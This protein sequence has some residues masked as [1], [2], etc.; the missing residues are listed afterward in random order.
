MASFI[1]SIF[2]KI[3]GY[4]FDNMYLRLA[5]CRHILPPLL[6]CPTV[7]SS[8]EKT[9]NVNSAAKRVI[10]KTKSRPA[11]IKIFTQPQL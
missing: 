9:V 11:E 10:C 5:M 3:T 1:S 8:H 4:L 2:I 7:V 6:F